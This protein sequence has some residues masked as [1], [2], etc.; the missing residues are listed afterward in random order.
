MQKA[1]QICLLVVVSVLMFSCNKDRANPNAD[2]VPSKDTAE[3]PAHIKFY[4]YSTDASS[5]TWDFDDDST[6]TETEPVHYFPVKGTYEISLTAK[7]NGESHTTTKNLVILPNPTSLSIT[8]NRSGT[9]FSLLVF[10][11]EGNVTYKAEFGNLAPGATTDVIKAYTDYVTIS[12]L[13]APGG[14]EGILGWNVVEANFNSIV[15]T[16][17]SPFYWGK[18]LRRDLPSTQGKKVRVGDA[19]FISTYRN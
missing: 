5:Y 10:W 16:D 12:I 13:N 4:N 11:V 15:L 8:N 18:S 19:S 3:A 9:L 1:F 14:N 7:K 6:S 2:F 17:S